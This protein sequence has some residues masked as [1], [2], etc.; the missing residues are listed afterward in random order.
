VLTRPKT[1][2]RFPLL[3][4]ESVDEFSRDVERKSVVL[5]NVPNAFSLPRDPKDE[6]YLNVAIAAN[7]EFL[8]SRDRDLL[9]LMKDAAFRQQFPGLT[10]LD[11]AAFLQ[12]MANRDLTEKQESS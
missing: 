3:T 9:D 4:A 12:V 7:A 6:P 11:P 1:Q 2:R 8:V 5:P 10:I